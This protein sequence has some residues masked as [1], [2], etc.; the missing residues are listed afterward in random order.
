MK[1][2]EAEIVNL[3][4]LSAVPGVGCNRIRALYG[5]FHSFEHVFR[6]SLSDL[7]SVNGIDKKTAENIK[8]VRDDGFAED[9]LHRLEKSRARLITFWDD[10][11]PDALKQI[12]D[13]PAYLFIKGDFQPQDCYGVAV[14]GTRRPSSYGKVA[15]E[16]IVRELSSVG[17][18]V[19]SGLAY[20]V[21]TIAH[22]TALKHGNRTLAV[23]GSGVDIIY[24]YD[25]RGLAQEV[26]TRG[27]VISE[28]PFGTGPDRTNFPRRNRIICGLSLGVI[29]VEAGEKSGSLIT[30]AM[31]L[32]Q[33]RE[34]FAVPG[35]FNSPGSVG[36]NALIKQGASI[37]TSPRDVI[38]ELFPKLEPLLKEKTDTSVKSNLTAEEQVVYEVLSNEPM[39]IDSIARTLR[40]PASKVLAVLLTLELKNVVKQ[41]AG[42]RF[43]RL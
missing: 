17:I 6:A 43:V 26:S 14:V 10:E 29:V 39:H 36:T 16:K 9:Q 19:V 20:G 38:E 11:Y 12:Y 34:V 7:V 33:N 23:L 28:F 42:K 37:V 8:T 22:Q 35:N 5:A 3:L 25:N 18:P 31:A 15:T 40:L 13:P 41:L 27:A 1:L 24:P 30:A 32:E 21:D 2:S 4:R